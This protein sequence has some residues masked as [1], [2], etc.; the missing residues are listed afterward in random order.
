MR[1]TT[2]IGKL[3]K[4]YSIDLT[5]INLNYA[6]KYGDPVALQWLLR[7]CS[8][9]TST[10]GK[11]TVHRTRQTKSSAS[12]NHIDHVSL[13][14]HFITSWEI[15][16]SFNNQDLY[17]T[18]HTVEASSSLVS[19]SSMEDDSEWI[20]CSAVLTDLPLKGV[21][22][23][24]VR[25]EE[26]PHRH[27]RSKEKQFIA[28]EGIHLEM[29]HFPR[30]PFH[31]IGGDNASFN[32]SLHG[33]VSKFETKL[34][35]ESHKALTSLIVLRRLRWIRDDSS[36]TLSW[37]L[38]LTVYPQ[39]KK[40]TAGQQ[41]LLQSA[42]RGNHDDSPPDAHA[43]GYEWRVFVFTS[44]GLYNQA[45]KGFC[46]GG[47]STDGESHEN[48][49]LQPWQWT[50]FK[51]TLSG[52][53]LNDQIILVAKPTSDRLD[54]PQIMLD[55]CVVEV[56]DFLLSEETGVEFP[57]PTTAPLPDCIHSCFHDGCSFHVPF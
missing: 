40:I 14:A 57:L 56:R 33:I 10:V 25:C 13:A 48:V 23:I 41:S 19:M 42:K 28:F 26:A 18:R 5:S 47:G 1:C 50:D 4:L 39:I 22:D 46:M 29:N 35:L 37:R 24:Y 34:N 8:V 51:V 30:K 43:L 6:S 3:C 2:P 7:P 21:I 44:F 16:V 49:P 15:K 45:D 52:L 11:S 31:V 53:R 36:A 17:S 12:S 32:E 54:Y 38:K 20:P 55:R 9:G 27:E